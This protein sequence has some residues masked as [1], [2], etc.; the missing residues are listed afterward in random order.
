[1]NAQWIKR[2]SVPERTDRVI[3]FLREAGLVEDELPESERSRLEEIVRVLDD[4]LKTVADIVDQAGF[5]LADDVSYATIALESVLAKPGADELLA[6]LSAVLREAPNFE[7]STLEDTLRG[8]AEDRGLSLG[9]VV[10]PLRVAVTGRKASPGIFET[11]WL[12]G[13]EKT[14]ARLDAAREMTTS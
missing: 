1:M 8:F 6:G 13:R 4:R 9:K 7:P 14:C 2:L 3:P 12:L 5:F 11:L 10:Q